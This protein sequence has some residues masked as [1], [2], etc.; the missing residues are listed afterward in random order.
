MAPLTA[1]AT[2]A[3]AACAV[4]QLE[5]RSEPLTCKADVDKMGA[6]KKTTAKLQEILDSGSLGRRGGGPGGGAGEGPGG[7]GVCICGFLATDRC[8]CVCL[9]ACVHPP[10]PTCAWKEACPIA[11]RWHLL[12]LGLA[13]HICSCTP[14]TTDPSHAGML[15]N[16]AARSLSHTQTHSFNIRSGSH[17]LTVTRSHMKTPMHTCTP[18]HLHGAHTLPPPH[19]QTHT[20]CTHVRTISR[21]CAHTRNPPDGTE[22]MEASEKQQL[23]ILFMQVWGAAEAAATLWYNAGVGMPASLC[24]MAAYFQL[25]I[26]SCCPPASA[27]SPLTWPAPLNHALPGSPPRPPRA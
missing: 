19:T 5:H 3:L 10:A 14:H 17:L 23:I 24:L 21:S 15:L 11:R 13:M 20:Q 1:A 18:A 22:V 27:T 9:C 8:V 16:H 2:A 4:G 6:G 26:F 12:A 7:G 25:P